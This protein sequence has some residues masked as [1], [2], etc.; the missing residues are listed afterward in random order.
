MGELEAEI[1]ELRAVLATLNA[2]L[3]DSA[4]DERESLPAYAE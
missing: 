1:A 4:T 3:A 2:R